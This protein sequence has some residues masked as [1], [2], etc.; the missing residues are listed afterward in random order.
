MDRRKFLSALGASAIGAD[1]FFDARAQPLKVPRIGVL[2]YGAPQDPQADSVLRG[3]RGLGYET[4]R[5][6][7]IDFRHADENVARLPAL[8][9]DLARLN[10]D[11]IM[12]ATGDVAMAVREVTR[13]IPI[14]FSISSDPVQLGLVES[15]ARPGGNATGVTYLQDEL[16]AKRLQL[17]K[18]AA[19]KISRIAFL[20]NPGHLDNERREAER[21]A[22]IIGVELLPFEARNAVEIRSACVAA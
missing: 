20:S 7:T 11:V 14:V 10:P 3:L 9:A 5:N 16:A 8:A 22:R 4:G 19:P 2:L 18:E 1:C 17:F 15:L 12:A 13:K 6:I 21:A